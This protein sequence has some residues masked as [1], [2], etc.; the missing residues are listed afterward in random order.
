VHYKRG[1]NSVPNYWRAWRPVRKK[2][3]VGEPLREDLIPFIL[4]GQGLIIESMIARQRFA[5][6]LQSLDA[7]LPL[8]YSLALRLRDGGISADVIFWYVKVELAALDRLYGM[9]ETK[10]SAAHHAT[11]DRC[12]G[13]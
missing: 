11:D 1:G 9:A 10:H 12:H 5:A 4:A 7:S 13:C 2:I 8:P 6:Y 3:H